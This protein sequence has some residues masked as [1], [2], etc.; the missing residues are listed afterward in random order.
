[1]ARGGLGR[2]GIAVVAA[3]SRSR[4]H[5]R[6]APGLAPASTT[7]GGSLSTLLNHAAP[8]FADGNHSAPGF[9]DG[10]AD[11]NHSAPGLAADRNHSAPE[12]EPLPHP[13]L[14]ILVRK[15][16]RQNPSLFDHGGV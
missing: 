6:P 8:G 2:A 7:E 13:P 3:V 10:F 15:S 12:P 5:I 14:R 16:R 1:M 9:A 4:E 11:E